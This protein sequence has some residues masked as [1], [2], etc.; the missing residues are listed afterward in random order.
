MTTENQADVVPVRRPWP[1]TRW[2]T[3]VRTLAL[4]AVAGCVL[5]AM[6]EAP[7]ID[8]ELQQRG[9]LLFRD[10]RLSGDRSRSCATCHPGGGGDGRVYLGAEEVDPG[11]EGGRNTPSLR[12]AWQSPP[13]LWDGSAPTLR[14]AL[15]R[16]LAVEMRGGGAQ[17][18]ELA[19]LETYVLS[20]PPFDRGRLSPDGAP[21][22]PNTLRMRRGF[23]NFREW[24]CALCHPPRRYAWGRTA[25]V[26]TGSFDVPTLLGVADTGPWGHDGRFE[27]LEAAVRAILA[28]RGESADDLEVEYLLEYLKLL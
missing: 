12:G 1:S 8:P 6:P 15:E 24:K 18:S 20:I 5:P 14:D 2:P 13:Y 23:E 16:M 9:A 22:E 19:A 11:T 4:A 27:T 10:T 21:R 7:L 3:R 25:D 17:P 26:G 28:A